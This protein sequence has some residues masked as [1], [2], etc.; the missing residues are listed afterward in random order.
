MVQKYSIITLFLFLIAA[1]KTESALF[2]EIPALS[3]NKIE[4]IQLE[5]KDSIVNI[6][7]NYTDGNGD[8]GLN[9]EDT[10]APYN[11]GSKFF[12]NL[13]VEL[14][15]VENGVSSKIAIPFSA[16]TINFNDRITNL[17]PTGKNKS[18]NCW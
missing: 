5:G 3:F 6:Y 15:T 13:F 9:S 18:I 2:S 14:Y 7:I 4:K 17:T 11:Y 8:I 10:T 1:C 12:Y 16:D